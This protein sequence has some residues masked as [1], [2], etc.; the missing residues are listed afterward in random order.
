MGK[1][2]PEFALIFTPRRGYFLAETDDSQ[3]KGRF[4]SLIHIVKQGEHLVGIA[5][6]FG[7]SSFKTIFDHPENAELKKLR[8]NPNILF[9]GDRL[10]IPELLTKEVDRSTEKKHRFVRSV[11]SVQ[12][13]VRLLDLNG[14]PL[15]GTCFVKTSGDAVLMSESGDIFEGPIGSD[16][17]KGELQLR[18]GLPENKLIIQYTLAVGS[19]DPIKTPSGQRAR[20]NNL[21]YFAGFSESNTPQLKMAIEEFQADNLDEIKKLN[22]AKKEADGIVDENGTEKVLEKKYGA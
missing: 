12:I 21:G 17:K 19:L 11:D 18:S 5:R 6:Q 15:K 20:L 13:R 14:Q 7:F 9:P 2:P 8:K 1:N 10:F 22:P 16:E 3:S 4:M